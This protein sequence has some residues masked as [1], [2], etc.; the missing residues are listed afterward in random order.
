M[1]EIET[2]EA[3]VLRSMKYR[4][5]SKI[6]TLYTR[7]HG[8]VSVI[9]K[10]AR[11]RSKFF[12]S[13]LEPMS[14]ISAVFYWKEGRDLQILS[15]AS[16][17]RVFHGLTVRLETMAAGLAIVEL[18]QLV[19]HYQEANP[20]LF[21]LILG[22]LTV[23]DAREEDPGLVFCAFEL[24]L[25]GLLGFAPVFDRCLTCGRD[26][27]KEIP[28]EPMEVDV[29]RGGI[30]CS[31]CS[32]GGGEGFFHLPP[33]AVGR[34]KSFQT[35]SFEELLQAPPLGQ[36]IAE[37]IKRFLWLFLQRHVPGLRSLRSE[38]VFSTI[39]GGV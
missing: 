36:E 15:E 13:A 37:P 32:S 33:G 16:H 22:S 4:S 28:A 2:T 23:L 35:M 39:L 8:K 14:Y 18:A 10:A 17:L 25:A 9:A 26:M 6:V 24:R 5:S 7:N 27:G 12:G 34:L 19:T 38:K 3:I 1:S 31:R 21:N 29:D 20:E 30:R 11:E